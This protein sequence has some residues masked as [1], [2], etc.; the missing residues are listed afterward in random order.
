M[1]FLIITIDPS[2]ENFHRG[3]YR[4]LGESLRARGHDCH[5]MSHT[6]VVRTDDSAEE[7][8]HYLESQGLVE[9]HDGFIVAPVSGDWYGRNCRSRADC[10]RD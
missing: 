9:P 8:A 6:W 5:A 1:G 2:L 7:F 4:G 3:I 10:F